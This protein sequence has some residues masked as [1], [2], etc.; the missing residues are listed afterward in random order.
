MAEKQTSSVVVITAPFIISFPNLL[1]AKPYMENGKPKGDPQYT[2]EGISELAT[3]ADWQQ[4]NK[5]T[6]EFDVINVEKRLVALAKEQ[7]GEDFSVKDSVKHGG[8]SWPFK[9]G[10]KKAD[11]KGEKGEHYRGKKFWR[12]KALAEI[13]GTPNS[14]DLWVAVDGSI[15][16]LVRGTTAGDQRIT[17][18]FYGGAVCTAELGAVAGETAQGK[19]VTLYA[20]AVVFQEDGPRLGGGSNI[21]RMYGVKGGQ[22]AIDP[23]KGMNKDLDDEIPF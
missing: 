8:L 17:Q 22:S 20:N 15:E 1:V 4:V 23:T 7:W 6:G 13:N 11:E 21:E 9:S 18:L 14:P 10:D 19:Y 2:F 5:D 16:R 3:L 12:A